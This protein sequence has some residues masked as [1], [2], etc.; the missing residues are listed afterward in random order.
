MSCRHEIELGIPDG[1]NGLTGT[2]RLCTRTN[3]LGVMAR[4]DKTTAIASLNYADAK[5]LR[6]WLTLV[7]AEK[8]DM[9]ITETY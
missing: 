6:D 9:T 3:D 2:L 1:S 8:P 5:A 4:N 7:L